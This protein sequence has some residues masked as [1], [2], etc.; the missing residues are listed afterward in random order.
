MEVILLKDIKR[1]GEAGEVKKVADGYARNY[2]IPRGLA[3]IATEGVLKDLRVKRQIEEAKEER[4]RSDATALAAK[5]AGIMLT[6]KV[7]AGETGRLYGSITRGDIAA[8]LEAKTGLPFDKRKIMLEEPIRQLGT[9]KVPIRLL[10]TLVP[11]IT[12]VV[13]QESSEA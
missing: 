13:E 6:F 3:V 12:V 7:K 9:H 5:L 11:E 8:E 4:I 2:L 10:S 1:L